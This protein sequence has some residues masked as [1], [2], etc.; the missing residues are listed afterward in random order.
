MCIYIYTVYEF[1]FHGSS[2]SPAEAPSV[3]FQ[4]PTAYAISSATKT[5]GQPCRASKRFCQPTAPAET[6][7]PKAPR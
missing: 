7:K 5:S 3:P 6:R 2:P 4:A 1:I